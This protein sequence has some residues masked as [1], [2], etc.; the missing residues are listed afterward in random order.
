[1]HLAFYGPPA[2]ALTY[3]G[4]DDF[5]EIYRLLDADGAPEQAS[6][7]FAVSEPYQRH[8]AQRLDASAASHDPG[9]PGGSGRT[10]RGGEPGWLRQLFWLTVRYL[11]VL[12]GDRIALA[13]LFAAAP[14]TAVMLSGTLP[15]EIFAMTKDEGGNARQALS[16]LFMLITSSI[17]LGGFVSSRSIAEEGP[18]YA[19]ERLVN[20]KIAPY[21]LS[22]ALVLGI[23]SVIQSVCLV[24]MIG[25]KID[26][27]GGSEAL[28]DIFVVVVAVN[29]ISVAAGLMA[30]A[31]AS[32]GLQATLIIIVFMMV[33]LAIAGG[34]VPIEGMDDVAQT[35][36]LLTPGRWALSL[37][38]MIVDINARIDAQL[39]KNTFADQFTVDRATCWYALGGLFVAFLLLAVVGLKRR[40]PR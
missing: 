20:L 10:S 23:F 22:K 25:G 14:I 4:V 9:T 33:Q 21:L 19:R 40:D 13:V 5:V 2:E 34:I 24:Y 15:E 16:L 6:A 39:P 1:G 17:L 28:R 18:I 30:S 7:R 26:I 27:P 31:I 3:F 35:L 32:N 11:W 36:S 8:I 12:K 37:L 38:G 29:L